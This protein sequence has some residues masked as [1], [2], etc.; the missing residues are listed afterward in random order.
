MKIFYYM[1]SL[2]SN[3][4]VCWVVIYRKNDEHKEISIP[5]GKT[6]EV[7]LYCFL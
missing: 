5:A 7:R 3:I 4:E 6:H 2:V 1:V